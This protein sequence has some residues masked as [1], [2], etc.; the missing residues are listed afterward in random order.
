MYDLVDDP[1]LQ[2]RGYFVELDH[3]IHGTTTV[4]GSRFR[5]SRTPARVDRAAPTLGRDNRYVLESILG[6]SAERLAALEAQGV[7]Q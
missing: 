3:P 7:L 5:L 6:Y 1:Q 4:E 2:H